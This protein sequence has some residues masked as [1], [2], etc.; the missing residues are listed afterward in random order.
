M[1]KKK[2]TCV[3]ILNPAPDSESARKKAGGLLLWSVAVI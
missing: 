1:K 3:R 2:K